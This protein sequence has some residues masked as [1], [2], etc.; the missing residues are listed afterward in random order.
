MVQIIV[1]ELVLTQTYIYTLGSI[2]YG[3]I[4]VDN[5]CDSVTCSALPMNVYGGLGR[6]AQ[7]MMSPISSGYGTNA[8]KF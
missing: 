4:Y 6:S 8:C 2:N 5:V 3:F 1:L 7:G